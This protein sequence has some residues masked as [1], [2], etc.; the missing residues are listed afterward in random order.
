M[1][2]GFINV[3]F[4]SFG[5]VFV[6][7]LTVSLRTATHQWCFT[8]GHGGGAG[9]LG[10]GGGAGGRPS[11]LGRGQQVCGEDALV[12]DQQ[13]SSRLDVS[14]RQPERRPGRVSLKAEVQQLGE[15]GRVD[16]TALQT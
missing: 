4:Y 16:H 11:R 6:D 7:W 8:C 12:V 2:H 9:L 14:S 1:P 15:G 13:L 3:C 10:G 5:T